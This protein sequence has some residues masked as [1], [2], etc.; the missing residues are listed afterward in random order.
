MHPAISTVARWTVHAYVHC[1]NVWCTR[2]AWL[3]QFLLS[4]ALIRVS[5]L[6]LLLACLCFSAKL[7]QICGMDD[8]IWCIY[9]ALGRVK[10]CPPRWCNISA[11]WAKLNPLINNRPKFELVAAVQVGDGFCIVTCYPGTTRG[12][13]FALFAVYSR[14]Q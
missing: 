2:I 11:M 9:C 7:C 10:V 3:C 4:F 13:E 12:S 5:N 8:G 14:S 6:L 1:G